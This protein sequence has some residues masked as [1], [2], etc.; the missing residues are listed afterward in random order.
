V[1]EKISAQEA[2]RFGA[3][4]ARRFDL[5]AQIFSTHVIKAMC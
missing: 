1:A 2:A 4:F 3:A 5:L